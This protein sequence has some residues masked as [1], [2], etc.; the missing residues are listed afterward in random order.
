MV[1]LTLI[2]LT[3]DE[4]LHDL[5]EIV[6]E[7]GEDYVY[8][9]PFGCVYFTIDQVDLETTD[10]ADLW[11]VP[12]ACVIGQLLSRH[13][14]TLANLRDENFDTPIRVVYT[15]LD[16]YKVDE[17]VTQW[18]LERAQGIQDVGRTYGD[19][20]SEVVALTPEDIP[21]GELMEINKALAS[22]ED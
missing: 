3:K 5:R 15:D 14:V 4:V 10:D 13:G 17:P 12:P 1:G 11:A 22:K 7:K 19:M 2:T 9:N 21:S 16:I 8:N 6:A 18:I 20:L